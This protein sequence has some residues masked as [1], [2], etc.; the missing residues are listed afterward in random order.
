M[1]NKK[2]EFHDEIPFFRF[3]AALRYTTTTC[4]VRITH[5][6]FNYLMIWCVVRTL[7]LGVF[8]KMVVYFQAA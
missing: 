6:N 4:R 2:T 7:H 3:Q 5:R 1:L 8:V